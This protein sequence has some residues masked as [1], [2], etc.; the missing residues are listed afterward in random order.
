VTGVI[1]A[2]GDF[3]LSSRCREWGDH[4]GPLLL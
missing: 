2:T 3:E 4:P 1:A